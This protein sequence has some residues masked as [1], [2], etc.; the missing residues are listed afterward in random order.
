M[1]IIIY[2]I[3]GLGLGIYAY[4]LI[5]P[6]ADLKKPLY[7]HTLEEADFFKRKVLDLCS[8]YN[9][10]HLMELPWDMSNT[11]YDWALEKIPDLETLMKDPRPLALENYLDQETI[12]KLFS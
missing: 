2:V 12:N 3:I 9:R 8:K 10:R 7:P 1:L 11:A 4:L 5:D 6:F